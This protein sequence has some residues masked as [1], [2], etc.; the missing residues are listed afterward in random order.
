M[1]ELLERGIARDYVPVR[2]ALTSPRGRIDFLALATQSSGAS[3]TLPCLHHPRSGDHLL[4]QVVL[5]GLGLAHRNA[6]DG[7]LASLAG[8]QS[9]WLAEYARPVRLSGA[10]LNQA[11]RA[12]NR[13]VAP[14]EY[15]V[16]L[17]EILHFGSLVDL[18]DDADRSQP[19]PG[20]LFD[21]NRFFQSL[22]E[23]FLSENLPGLHVQ[24]EHGLTDMM[25]YMDAHNPR[26]RRS[27]SPRPDYAITRKGKV[28]SLLD[29][30]YRDLWERSLPR[31]MLYQL[32]IYA[33]SQPK[34]AT[35]AILFPTTDATARASRI[36]I[37]EPM[38]GGSA[39]FVALRPVKLGR[40]VHVIE[41]TG[42]YG[43]AQREETARELA[44][45]VS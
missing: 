18:I 32:S 38:A 9:R 33:L 3:A 6:E 7:A 26:Q 15:I 19:L 27:P 35:A 31:D 34:G 14:Y 12:L 4:N 8:R 45:I 42:A 43:R 10:V 22:L 1:R 17:I 44:G 23:R 39:G 11:K 29:A 40:L 25:R 37:R 5:A 41:A 20:F 30:K 28:L 16:R 24:C 36:E 21:M 13:L 2:E